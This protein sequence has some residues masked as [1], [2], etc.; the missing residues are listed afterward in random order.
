MQK[1]YYSNT[2]VGETSHDVSKVLRNTYAL[3]GMT[4]LF[5]ALMS[6]VSIAVNAPYFG[7]YS[8]IPTFALI[9]AIEKFKNSPLGIVLAFALTGWLGFTLGPI[10]S[11]YVGISGIEP[12]LTALGG[13]AMIFF[14]LSGYI[15]VTK[16]DMS[17]AT[18]FI[19]AGAIVLIVAM[20]ANAF[21]N[22]SALSLMISC[23]FLL[24]SS[25]VILWQTSAIIHGG[26]RNYVS[27]TVSLYVSLYNIFTILLSFLGSDD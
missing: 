2:N 21:L 11:H 7:L 19:G 16:K 4:I 8:L 18:G 14:G 10:L 22:I 1:Q 5:S 13:T 26:E 20:I 12:V 27:A 17:F 6:V 15:L 9:F 3:L 23:A 24:F 25:L